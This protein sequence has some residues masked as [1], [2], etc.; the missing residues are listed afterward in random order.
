MQH[1]WRQEGTTRVSTTSPLGREHRTLEALVRDELRRQIVTGALAPGTRLV[2]GA[3]AD[4]LGVS[5]GPV[6]E[7]IR[8]L[9]R[10]GFVVISPRRGASVAD[11]SVEEALEC[12]EVRAALEGLAATLAAERRSPEDL[13]RLRGVLE[14]GQR[15]LDVG[16]W[17]ALAHL[18][19]EFHR[20]LA[21]ASGNGQLTALMAQYARRIAWMFSHSAEQRGARAWLEHAAIVEAIAARDPAAA[22]E[23][24]RGHIHASR[25]TFTDA[26]DGQARRPAP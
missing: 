5:R 21:V 25:Q 12:Y 13:D 8:E 3:L 20:A 19:N 6:R 17:D 14:E 1:G 11:V 15:M 26:V 22:A 7:A 9:D 10:E 4:E 24:A 23:C 16:R 2:E 18:N